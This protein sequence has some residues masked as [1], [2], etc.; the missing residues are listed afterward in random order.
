MND[1]ILNTIKKMLGLDEDYDAFDTD[2]IVH[3]NTFLGV[4]NTLGVGVDGFTIEDDG[5][6]WN[7]FLAGSNVPLNEVKTYLYLRVRQIFDPPTSGIL[8]S[9]IDKQIDELGW[10]ITTKVE[11]TV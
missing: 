7:D 4:L 10:R 1:S 2:V 9:A 3:I 5:A 6:T 8:S 11:C